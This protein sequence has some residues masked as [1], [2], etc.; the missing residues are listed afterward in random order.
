MVMFKKYIY[1]FWKSVEEALASPHLLQAAS[2]C[3]LQRA[4]GEPPAT[5]VLLP[6]V[7]S[8]ATHPNLSHSF[9]RLSLSLS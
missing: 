9:L 2:V 1:S 6:R 5:G 3:S 8:T 4:T 7:N